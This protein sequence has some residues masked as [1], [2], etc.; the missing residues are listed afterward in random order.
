MFFFFL[1]V[2]IYWFKTVKKDEIV[3]NYNFKNTNTLQ[4]NINWFYIYIYIWPFQ[5]FKLKPDFLGETDKSLQTKNY[6]DLR[7]WQESNLNFK[8]LVTKVPKL[9]IY[10]FYSQEIKLC[11]W[12]YVSSSGFDIRNMLSQAFFFII[13]VATFTLMF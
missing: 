11:E 1:L 7:E 6:N 2:P 3:L 9:T 10:N 5:N 13:I 12:K 4:T 8:I